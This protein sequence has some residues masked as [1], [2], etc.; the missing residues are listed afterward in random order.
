MTFIIASLNAPEYSA[1]SIENGYQLERRTNGTEQEQRVKHR[2]QEK[3]FAFLIQVTLP[4]LTKLE[5]IFFLEKSNFCN[6]Q[7]IL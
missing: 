1:I 4:C 2:L 6:L 3:K 7:G 5:N